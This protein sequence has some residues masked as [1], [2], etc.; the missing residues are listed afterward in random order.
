MRRYVSLLV[1]FDLSVVEVEFQSSKQ[2][3]L[4]L[5]LQENTNLSGEEVRGRI[6][7]FNLSFVV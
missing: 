4:M 2:Q 3:N 6:S 7:L 5:G 1:T